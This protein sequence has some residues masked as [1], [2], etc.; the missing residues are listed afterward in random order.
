[1]NRFPYAARAAALIAALAVLAPATGAHAAA[2]N[3]K[4]E[5]KCYQTMTKAVGAVMKSKAKEV[6]ACRTADISGKT[7]SGD[8]CATLSDKAVAK[9][10][11]SKTKASGKT[12]KSCVSVCS[13]SNDITC[14]NEST[15]PPNGDRPEGCTGKGGKNSFNSD[16]K[17]GFPGPFCSGILVGTMTSGED[18]GECISEIGER[19]SDS[20]TDNV[21]GSLGTSAGLSKDGA[22]CLKSLGKTLPKTAIAVAKA[23]GKCRDTQNLLNSKEIDVELCPT[24]DVATAEAIAK[25][26]AKLTKAVNKC[27]PA[28]FDE[29]DLCGNGV[30]LTDAAGAATCLGDLVDEASFVIDAP[31]DRD[32]VVVGLINA[33]YPKSGAAICGDDIANQDPNPFFLLGEECDGVDDSACPGE[34]LP[35]GDLFECTC[36]DRPRVRRLGDGESSD[37]DTGWTGQSHQSKVGDGSGFVSDIDA[38]SCDCDAFTDATCTGTSVDNICDVTSFVQPT[39]NNNFGSGLS[40]DQQGNNNGTSSE[41]DCWSCDDNSLNPGTYCVNDI[42]QSASELLCN[43]Q[44]FDDDTNTALDP[45]T[46]CNA[47]EDCPDGSTCLGRCNTSA[48]CVFTPNGSPIPIS[49]G[50]TSVCVESKFFTNV[51]GTTNIVTGE[52]TTNYEL[53]SFTNLGVSLDAPCPV[54]GGYCV[55]G[56]RINAPCLGNCELSPHSDCLYDLD[57]DLVT[58]SGGFRSGDGALG[59]ATNGDCDLGTCTSNNGTCDVSGA[60][61]AKDDDCAAEDTACVKDADTTCFSGLIENPDGTHQ[62]FCELELLCNEGANKGSPCR[63]EAITGFGVV[64]NDC[65][66][67]SGKNISGDGLEIVFA[68]FTSETVS[69]GDVSTFAPCSVP[70]FEN[71]GCPCPDLQNVESTALLTKPNGC[72]GACNAGAE[73]GQR[74]GGEFTKCVGGAD[75]GVFCDEDSDCTSSDC[76]GNPSICTAGDVSSLDELCANNGDCG[77]GGLCEDACPSGRCTPL[78]IPSGSCSGGVSDGA[79]CVDDTDCTGGSCVAGDPHEGLCVA[80]PALR[81]C[82]GEGQEW[83]VCSISS[84]GTQNDCENGVDNIPGND[85]DWPGAG[86]CVHKPRPC[87]LVD[88]GLHGLAEGGDTINGNGD[89]TNFLSVT[90]YCVPPVSNSSVNSVAGMG[91]PGRLRQGGVSVPNFSSL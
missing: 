78:C 89:P 28:A 74:C 10:E 76:S 1:M 35:T 12:G 24:A 40:C 80:G 69:H 59:C 88:G 50:G 32:F 83:R 54:C 14:I 55:D 2:V 23:I 58:C 77:G 57:C 29:L 52:H 49:S 84:I 46:A 37:L 56:P 85:D 43:S 70:G 51:T 20:I 81:R 64:S 15:C 30:G 72:D 7:P 41:S 5:I 45:V 34:C 9:F 42:E 13:V 4:Q 16:T 53:R 82:N 63:P 65:P 60:R 33:A 44:C 26:K 67:I 38:A 71:Y 18:F 86:F 48:S 22:K 25:A 73:Q 91:G 6:A 66:S 90:A 17:M 62:G 87:F 27:T 8:L 47:Q 19:V 31:Q 21:Y 79:F 75:D 36:G 39:C 61:C 3:K 68:P 11:K